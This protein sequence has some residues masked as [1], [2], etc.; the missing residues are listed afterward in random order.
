[1]TK[2]IDGQLALPG[3]AIR[4]GRGGRTFLKLIYPFISI[5]I[6]TYNPISL[7]PH[8]LTTI[9]AGWTNPQ[10]RLNP[11]QTVVGPPSTMSAAGLVKMG[12]AVGVV[13]AVGSAG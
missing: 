2:Q 11:T 9:Q 12:S 7:Y 5:S 10:S 3:G 1:M 8:F 4:L 6:F 13:L